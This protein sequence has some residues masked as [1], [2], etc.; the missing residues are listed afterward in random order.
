[1]SLT[2]ETTVWCDNNECGVWRQASGSAYRLRRS[3]KREGWTHE[4]GG[5][6]FCPRCSC[7]RKQQREE[8]A[9]K[10]CPHGFT[11]PAACKHCVA[12]GKTVEFAPEEDEPCAICGECAD[13]C[14]GH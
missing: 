6:D 10:A 2:R 3:L 9:S 12:A 13:E 8:A 5:K 11:S 7:D 14:P 1:M 4:P